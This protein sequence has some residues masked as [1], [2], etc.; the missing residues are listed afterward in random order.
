MKK[1]DTAPEDGDAEAK[2][3]HRRSPYRNRFLVLRIVEEFSR[4]RD[5]KEAIT[6]RRRNPMF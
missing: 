5:R 3:F 1:M 6:K 4:P 2:D